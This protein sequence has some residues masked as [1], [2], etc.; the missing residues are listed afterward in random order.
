[1]NKQVWLAT[2]Y[3]FPSTHS[4]RSPASSP[5]YSQALPAPSSV[6][7]KL[8]LIRKS[9]EIWGPTYTQNNLFLE[10]MNAEIYVEPPER[11]GVSLQILKAFKRGKESLMYR[12]FCHASGNM[13]I[14]AR[15]QKDRREQFKQLFRSICYWG[16]TDSFTTCMGVKEVSKPDLSNVIKLIHEV[17]IAQQLYNFECGIALNMVNDNLVW[18][19]LDDDNKMGQSLRRSV[20]TFG[21][22]VIERHNTSRLLQR[23]SLD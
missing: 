17:P 14:Y 3:H 10:I 18:E 2:L 6:T 20:F 21:L 8:G 1:M 13:V 22:Q 5:Y 19:D 23:R 7:V 12:E 4:I 11:V 15:V 9:C 16:R